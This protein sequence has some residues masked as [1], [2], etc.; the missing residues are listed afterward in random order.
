MAE[1]RFGR[2]AGAS[3][4]NVSQVNVSEISVEEIKA[5]YFQAAPDSGDDSDEAHSFEEAP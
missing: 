3:E 1:R 2:N 4:V 5:F